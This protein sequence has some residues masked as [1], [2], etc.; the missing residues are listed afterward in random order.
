MLPDPVSNSKKIMNVF[1]GAGLNAIEEAD[2]FSLGFA[3]AFVSSALKGLGKT[4]IENILRKKRESFIEDIICI[5]LLKR[6][7]KEDP[8]L[9]N[10]WLELSVSI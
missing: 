10:K 3:K 1:A 6:Q 7:V 2:V 8:T 4:L 5:T 9:I